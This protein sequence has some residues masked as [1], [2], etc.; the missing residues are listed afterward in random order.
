MTAGISFEN[1]LSNVKLMMQQRVVDESSRN[2]VGG[3]SSVL[4][5]LINGNLPI[6]DRAWEQANDINKTLPGKLNN[7]YNQHPSND[8][9]D[10]PLPQIHHD[11][12]KTF[13][14]E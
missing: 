9:I 4:L 2:Y 12:I 8:F 11:D 1:S 13:S 7:F 10:G 3:N 6:S 14:I 5:Y